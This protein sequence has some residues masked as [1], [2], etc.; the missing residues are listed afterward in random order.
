M[1]NDYLK[2][3]AVIGAA[4]KMGKAIS[5]LFLEEMAYREAKNF[6]VVGKRNYILHL[7][8]VHDDY[9]HGLKN[10]LKD[11]LIKSA[12]KKI[13]F[14]RK[15][16]EENKE[17]VSNK[18]VIHF[19]IEGAMEIVYCD[20]DFKKTKDSSIIFEAIAEDLDLKIRTFN[21]LKKN[22]N[23]PYFF[24]NTSS[25]PISELNNRVPL[26]H[27][28]VGFHFYNPP[29]IQKLVE[30]IVPKKIDKTLKDLTVS[31]AEKFKKITV[32]SNDIA[33]FIGNGHFMREIIFACQKVRELEKERPLHEAIFM[34]NYISEHFLLRPMGIFQLIDYVGLD[35]CRSIAKIM[36]T[37]L[38]ESGFD[39]PLIEKMLLTQKK[40]GQYPNGTQKPGFFEY[41]G[42]KIKGIYSLKNEGYEEIEQ[43][44]WVAN[45]IKELGEMPK[46]NT[47]WHQLLRNKNKQD[48]IQEHFFQLF[49]IESLGS[50][51]SKEFLSRSKEII[52]N[53]VKD[54]VAQS[55]EDVHTV[56]Y[57]GF[58]HLYSPSFLFEGA[59]K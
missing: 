8:D 44:P 49:E 16:F 9:L 23:N 12:E 19:F 48:L 36:N 6:G 33:G 53:L 52:E 58:Y 13:V 24:T 38:A 14:L 26:N 21:E 50:N 18:E 22:G 40:G 20:T 10:Y 5:F 30:I 37:Y 7:I 35:V 59:I 51:L 54:G 41:E 3:V 34:M 1:L 17:L 55:I 57:N 31:L 25:I 27:R 42:K 11:L 45:C 29:N 28:I 47:S 32:F 4:G 46:I 15:C 39:D 43:A 2:N 56:L